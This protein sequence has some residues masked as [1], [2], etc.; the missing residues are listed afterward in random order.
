M[1]GVSNAHAA[2]TPT[3]LFLYRSFA[4]KAPQVPPLELYL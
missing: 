3:N 2:D 1:E 4:H